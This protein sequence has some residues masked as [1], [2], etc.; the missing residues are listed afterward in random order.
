[1]YFL[2]KILLNKYSYLNNNSSGLK[3]SKITE[4]GD[5]D[6]VLNIFDYL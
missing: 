6:A 5:L 3:I 4:Y 1:M 2:F